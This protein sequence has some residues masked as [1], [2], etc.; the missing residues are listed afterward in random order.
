MHTAA[1]AAGRALRFAGVLSDTPKFRLADQKPD[2]AA[3]RAAAPL[4]VPGGLHLLVAAG[5]RLALGLA[6]GAA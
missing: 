6:R 4:T 5:G 2:E 1:S 3:H